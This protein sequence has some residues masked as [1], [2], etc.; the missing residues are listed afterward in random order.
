MVWR[1]RVGAAVGPGF[2]QPRS[3]HPVQL[4]TDEDPV[5]HQV[6]TLGGNT[7]VVVTDT[8]QTEFDRAVGGHVHQRRT[9]MQ[10]AEFV[11]GSERCTRVCRLVA[12]GPVVFGCMANGFVDGQP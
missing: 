10:R 5:A 11:W 1:A 9:V 8:G 6:P 4:I 3:E 12:D 7:L 2:A